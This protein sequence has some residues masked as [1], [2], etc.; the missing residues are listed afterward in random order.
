VAD[1]SY[2]SMKRPSLTIYYYTR[3]WKQFWSSSA[4]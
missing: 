3:C 4:K 1:Y 2:F